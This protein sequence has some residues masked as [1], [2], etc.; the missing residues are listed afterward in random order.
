[1]LCSESGAE[2]HC[3]SSD[4]ESWPAL[5][6]LTTVVTLDCAPVWSHILEVSDITY[7]RLGLKR[8][9]L[10]ALAYQT[11]WSSETHAYKVQTVSARVL[12]ITSLLKEQ[13]KII[14]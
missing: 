9:L 2:G 3:R 6:D 5:Q 14:F 12:G 1:M 7:K 11:L 4:T 8:Q 13:K 10:F